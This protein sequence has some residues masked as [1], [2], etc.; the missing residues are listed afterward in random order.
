[1]S[2]VFL[3]LVLKDALQANHLIRFY[4]DQTRK[5]NSA[6]WCVYFKIKNLIKCFVFTYIQSKCVCKVLPKTDTFYGICK[7][8]KNCHVKCPIFSIKFYLCY[9]RHIKRRFIVQRLYE[10]VAHEDVRVDF[11]FQ[12]FD[13]S[14][15]VK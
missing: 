15:F 11:L 3:S 5:F 9:T 2:F 13:I 7:K 4:L 14:K 6:P 10:H 1:M 12:F 8:D